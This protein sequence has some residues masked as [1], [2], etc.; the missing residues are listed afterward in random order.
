M[1]SLPPVV[2]PRAQVSQ[3]TNL[4]GFR[5]RAMKRSGLALGTKA[6]SRKPS[7][8]MFL[9]SHASR[10]CSN[11]QLLWL[12]L[13]DPVFQRRALIVDVIAD[14]RIVGCRDYTLSYN[15]TR[16]EIGPCRS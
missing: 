6:N 2:A 16:I 9:A 1:S 15:F 12:W 4:D 13:R 14:I 7:E 11:P 3:K 8:L 5:K 10:S